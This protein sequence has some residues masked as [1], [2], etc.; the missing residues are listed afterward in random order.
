VKTISIFSL[1]VISLWLIEN[2]QFYGALCN[3]FLTFY[4]FLSALTLLVV[5]QEG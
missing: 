5:W 3:Q 2:V 1:T 4:F